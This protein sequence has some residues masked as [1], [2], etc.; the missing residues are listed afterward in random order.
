MHSMAKFLTRRD[1]AAPRGFGREDRIDGA[2]DDVGRAERGVEA[3]GPPG[4][5][6]RFGAGLEM[7]PHKLSRRGVRSLKTED[8]LFAVANGENCPHDIVAR[9]FAGKELVGNRADDLPLIGICILRFVDQ[10]VVEPAVEQHPGRHIVAREQV[11]GTIDQIVVV[12][13]ADR[14]LGRFVGVKHGCAKTQKG[15]RTAG[16]NDGFQ[17]FGTADE[18]LGLLQQDIP[19]FW[20]GFEDA[21]RGE[22]S[23]RLP[24]SLAQENIEIGLERGSALALLRGQPICQ[25]AAAR[26]IRLPRSCKQRRRDAT[27]GRRL[28]RAFAA[29]FGDDALRRLRRLDRELVEDGSLSAGQPARPVQQQSQASPIAG[30][31][32]HQLGKLILLNLCGHFGQ[33]R[34]EGGHALGGN[35]HRVASRLHQ[36]GGTAFV[37]DLGLRCEAGFD[38]KPPQQR[39]AKTVNRLNL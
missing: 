18:A 27:Q 33:R 2:E 21:L 38:R 24:V 7:R 5:L 35:E 36:F 14:R 20:H 29:G 10:N 6:G 1:H 23:T 39:F 30:N 34:T 17:P 8:R 25:R 4:L 9:P 26:D 15:R 12:E 19:G 11:T 32:G 31:F 37:H 3:N 16:R 22:P 13:S 28:E